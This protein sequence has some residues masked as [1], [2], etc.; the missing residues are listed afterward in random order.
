MSLA[1]L[2]LLARIADSPPATR[3]FIAAVARRHSWMN[4][5][6]L[7][8]KR[9]YPGTRPRNDVTVAWW[10]GGFFPGKEKQMGL[11]RFTRAA[12]LAAAVALA[13]E[14]SARVV[15]GQ[16]PAGTLPPVMVEPP[17]NG[18]Q[19]TRDPIIVEPDPTTEDQGAPATGGEPAS[20]FDNAQLL[21][22]QNSDLAPGELY[23]YTPLANQSFSGPG[24]LVPGVDGGLRGLGL[25]AWD[26]PQHGTIINPQTLI[27]RQ[28]SDMSRALQNEV[29]VLVQQSARGQASPFIRGLTGQNVVILIDGVRVNNS[30]FRAGPN[31]YFN[32]ID[33][34][35]VERIEIIRGAQSVLWGSDAIGGVINV[36][37]KSPSR[38]RGDYGQQHFQEIFSTADTGTY[39]RLDTQAW[40]G[41]QGVY[42]GASYLNVNELEIGGQRGRQP[43]TDYDQYAGDLKYQLLLSPDSL[44][45]VSLQ[46]FE[47]MDVP[48]SDRFAPF[49]SSPR[50]TFFD[51]Q[52]RD[53]VNLRWEGVAYQP[54]F[55]AY[56]VT[57]NY[58]RQKE[59]V[60]ETRLNNNGT[61][62]RIEAGEF[63]VN[64][65]GTV[66]T[67]VKELDYAGTLSYGAD[68]YYDD[69]DAVRV[70]TNGNNGAPINP[71]TML[72][73]QFPNNSLY[74]RAGLYA[75]WSVPLTDR[76]SALTGVRYE[77]ANASGTTPIGNQNVFIE[78]SYQDWV[79]NAGLTYEVC[80]GVNLVGGYYEG[81]RAPNLDDLFAD[82]SFLQ[83]QFQSI[84]SVNVEPEY[85]QTYEVG[86]KYDGPVLR[87]QAFQYWNDFENAI[88][89]YPV[90]TSGP[91][92]GQFNPNSATVIRDNSD[93][94]LYGTELGGELLLD[95]WLDR[96]GY[97]L[98][99]N[100]WYTYGLDLGTN[101]VGAPSEPFSRIP[102]LTGTLGVRWR[103]PEMRRWVDVYVWMVDRADRYSLLNRADA[104]FIPG[105]TPG[106]ATLNLRTGR[107]WGMHDQH[108]LTLAIENITD[109]YYRVLGSGVDGAGINGII[110]YEFTY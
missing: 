107:T 4:Q 5:P 51:P 70:R 98:Y 77:N 22:P 68:Y 24:T 95:D 17:A 82:G 104:R 10:R 7:R 40:T 92:A 59:G 44:L 9:D 19:G 57:F 46:H 103:A 53:M 79:A 28:P 39:T 93:A 90:N 96:A 102:P 18:A 91:N 30:T 34:G 33:P 38:D 27:E 43:F 36:I 99:G 6:E 15:S 94:Y 37:S 49:T 89:R 32:T 11:A 86:L 41:N 71:P 100:V 72:M 54:L 83:G 66:V 14:N 88:L 61:V 55:D 101:G 62:N 106:Y 56:A 74:D 29:G 75:A 23:G 78:R 50:P 1:T 31:Q 8:I 105:G 73:P 65:F 108:R 16:E 60:R 67:L 58:S 48:R 87:L 26:A 25:S 109:Q 76:L 13:F 85:S 110:G 21:D 52:Q 35:M 80:E 20:V 3:S 12:A 64:T 47:Q 45:T 2:L 97:S 63:D 84:S 42:A 81:Y 69:I